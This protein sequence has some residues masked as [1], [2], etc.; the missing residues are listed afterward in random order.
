MIII[1][2]NAD[3]SQCGIGQLVY[4]VDDDVNALLDA[5]YENLDLS[6]KLIFQKFINDIGGLHGDIFSSLLRLAIPAFAATTKECYTDARNGYTFDTG[7]GSY[8]NFEGKVTL[9]RGVGANYESTAVNGLNFGSRSYPDG[10]RYIGIICDGIENYNGNKV[11]AGIG[12]FPMYTHAWQIPMKSGNV[13]ASQGVLSDENKNGNIFLYNQGATKADCL[14]YCDGKYPAVDSWTLPNGV[15]EFDL[16]YAKTI[17]SVG[18][19][20]L[21][22]GNKYPLI[23]VKMLILGT[24]LTRNQT[25][26][27]G[28]AMKNFYDSF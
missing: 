23:T 19:N 12:G 14:S 5:S 10:T 28:N 6:L 16:T 11:I 13:L 7:A 22:G 27:L 9:N 8:T 3:F 18:N 24:G 17:T 15:S 26:Q 2:K 21:S 25:I 4:K 1:N 20:W